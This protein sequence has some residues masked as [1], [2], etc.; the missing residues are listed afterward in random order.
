MSTLWWPGDHRAGTLMSDHALLA[1]MVRVEQA[2]LDELVAHRVAPANAAADL[3]VL[4]LPAVEELAV[5][6]EAGGNPVIP[7]LQA[8]RAAAPEPTATWLHRG[9]TS[10]DVLDTSLVL[11]ARAAVTVVRRQLADQ[12]DLLAALVREHRHTPMVARTLTQPAVPTTFGAKAATW[13]QAVLDADER[14][15][16]LAW[17]VQLGGAA[18]TLSA[19]VEL[20]GTDTARDLRTTFAARLELAPSTPWHTRRTPITTLGDAAVTV[21]DAAGRLANDALA[22]GRHEVGELRD[23]SAG[24]SSAMPHKA[25]PT[26]AVLVRRAALTTPQEAATLHLAAAQQVDE[27]ADG[28]WHAEWHPL[29]L[30]LRRTVVAVAQTTDLVRGLEVDTDRMAHNLAAVAPALHAE[31]RAVAELTGRPTS[32]TYLGVLDDLVT[33]TLGR[34]AEHP[35]ATDTTDSATRERP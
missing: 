2:W 31:Q 24:G 35:S 14:L 19:V 7:L 26:L 33:E 9:L 3:S 30:L 20:A 27:R 12:V 4:P 22:L 1:T 6:A 8:L 5:S 29:S 10:Q 28:G 13:L 18:G 15:A 17:P 25:N 32:E 23:G 34:A 16:S 21:T 11:C